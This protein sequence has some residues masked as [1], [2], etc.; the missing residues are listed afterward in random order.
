ML[1]S[2]MYQEN[3]P[4]QASHKEDG[5]QIPSTPALIFAKGIDS[6]FI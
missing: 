5:Y 3:G 1:A 2:A 6:Q 4:D